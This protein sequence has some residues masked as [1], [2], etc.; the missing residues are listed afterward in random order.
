MG[1]WFVAMPSGSEEMVVEWDKYE[2]EQHINWQELVTVLWILNW[3]AESL[4]RLLFYSRLTTW[5]LSMCSHV[6]RYPGRVSTPTAIT[7]SKREGEGERRREGERVRINTIM[8][9]GSSERLAGRNH[10][11]SPFQ[12]QVHG[13]DL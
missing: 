3:Y 2:R 7:G 6:E 1:G 8:H 11:M 4:Q 12:N 5:L 13:A 10:A 9:M